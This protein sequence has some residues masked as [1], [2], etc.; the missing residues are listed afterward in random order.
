M[1][2]TKRIQHSFLVTA[3]SLVVVIDVCGW[4]DNEKAA[5]TKSGRP[6]VVEP[7]KSTTKPTQTQEQAIAEIKKLGG[8]V[9]VDKKTPGKPVV[10]VIF[11]G[12]RLT[13]AALVHLKGLSKLEEL[14]LWNTK[15]TDAALVHLKGLTK[16]QRLDLN[17]TKISDAGLVHLK[18][19]IKLQKLG[20]ASTKISDAGLVHLKGLTK[21]QKLSLAST[22]ISD[23]GLV[24]LKGLT[25]PKNWAWRAQ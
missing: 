23:A 14:G 1:K 19:L 16:L 20:L 15:V 8:K 5:N 12:H 10:K 3:L 24:Y 13:A 11:F 7:K 21:L 22:K 4:S 9:E 25:K 2:A 18:G 6:A 17:D